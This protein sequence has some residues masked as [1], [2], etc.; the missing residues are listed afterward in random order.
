MSYRNVRGDGSL[1][2]AGMGDAPITDTRIIV[3]QVL[4]SRGFDANAL[5]AVVTKV[6][7]KY[8]ETI[9]KQAMERAAVS[10]GLT[11]AEI[12]LAYVP[13]V[14]W[15]I[16]VVLIVVQAALQITV[17]YYKN[18]SNQLIAATTNELKT[19]GAKYEAALAQLKDQVIAQESSAATALA[20]SGVSIPTGQGALQGLG[21]WQANLAR[22]LKRAVTATAIAADPVIKAHHDAFQAINDIVAKIPVPAVQN[23]AQ[24][25][26]ANEADF[27]SDYKTAEQK[28]NDF[29]EVG[30][31]EAQYKK[32]QE[33]AARAK[34]QALAE[35]ARQYQ[36]VSAN[37]Q[38]PQFRE[39]LRY[40]LATWI[41]TNPDIMSMATMPL[42]APPDSYTGPSLLTNDPSKALQAIPAVGAAA[43]AAALLFILGHK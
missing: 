31:G 1:Q 43:G 21:A 38:A 42:T 12:V 29:I 15:V 17:S 5:Q 11:V 36:V 35:F 41:R 9:K 37:I 20:L 13:V 2:L 23:L 40:S 24:K 6:M 22:D 32:A 39:Q 28:V 10:V 27:Y 18:L 8:D 26:N 25:L 3:D 19:Q 4:A 7:S 34:T 16:D 14:G 30:T 33:A